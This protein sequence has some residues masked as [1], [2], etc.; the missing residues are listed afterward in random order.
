MGGLR[1]NISRESSKAYMNWVVEGKRGGMPCRL[2]SL[3]FCDG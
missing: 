1:V 2:D 3:A